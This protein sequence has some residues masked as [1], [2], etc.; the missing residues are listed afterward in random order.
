M[1]EP[2]AGA[3][4]ADALV[5]VDGNNVIGARPDGWWRDRPAAARRLLDRLRAFAG[6]RPGPVV[7]V[8]DV[9][10]ADLPAGDHGGVTVVYP[11]RRGADAADDRI[12]A[13]STSG[14]R[15][16]RPTPPGW[17]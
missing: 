3:H 16:G 1:S 12:V 17:R 2:T 5:V 14:P 11:D 7:L 4:D 15:P 10:Q 9:P 8:L 13:P 6:A